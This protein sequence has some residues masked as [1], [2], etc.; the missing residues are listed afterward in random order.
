MLVK[1]KASKGKI[2]LS[3]E[4]ILGAARDAAEEISDSRLKAGALTIVANVSGKAKDLKKAL[5]FASEV[6]KSFI[7]GELL[8][9]V[10][11][12]LADAGNVS[13][14]R[15]V[16][17]KIED[18]DAYWCAEAF[19]HIGRISRSKEDFERARALVLRVNDSGNKAGLLADINS[20][21]RETADPSR[22]GHHHHGNRHIQEKALED[23]VIALTE[24]KSFE[25]AH[26]VASKISSA[27]WRSRAFAAIAIALAEAI[28]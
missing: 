19:I 18:I 21:M 10:A 12:T 4:E 26:M 7:K 28:K 3:F 27:Y 15:E 16:A 2:A 6:D 8:T 20:F 24:L 5:D 14:A 9:V 25:G 13:K 22:N 17:S 11:R 1:E 23:I